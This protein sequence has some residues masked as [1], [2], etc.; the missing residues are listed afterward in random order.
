MAQNNQNI[1]NN[2]EAQIIEKARRKVAKTPGSRIDLIALFGACLQA[3]LK[4]LGTKG[5]QAGITKEGT[6]I[7]INTPTINISEPMS[8]GR[9]PALETSTVEGGLLSRL[10]SNAEEPLT[11]AWTTNAV[12]PASAMITARRSRTAK[13]LLRI[14]SRRGWSC[15]I[16]AVVARA[17]ATA[18]R[19]R[20]VGGSDPASIS[21][22]RPPGTSGPGGS[23]SGS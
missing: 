10:G 1:E 21:T 15:S 18:R 22:R 4:A 16:A 7:A 19:V 8:A 12:S 9:N 20:S 17:P 3:A 5:I 11:T 14:T 2:A 23:R 13:T 6:E